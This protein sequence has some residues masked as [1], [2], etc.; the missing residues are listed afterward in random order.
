MHILVENKRKK[1]AL[2]H[3]NAVHDSCAIAVVGIDQSNISKIDSVLLL[4]APVF[5]LSIRGSDV[6]T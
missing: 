3:T 6:S 5:P 4:I 2:P 1:L